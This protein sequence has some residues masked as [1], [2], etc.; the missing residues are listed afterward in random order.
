MIDWLLSL[1]SASWRQR[2]LALVLLILTWSNFVHESGNLSADLTITRWIA[3]FT[4]AAAIFVTPICLLILLSNR[5]PRWFGGRPG[6]LSK[7][8]PQINEEFKRER[9]ERERNSRPF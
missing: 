8:L 4:M 5:A 9:E 1:P 7:T 2:F 6:P 3:W